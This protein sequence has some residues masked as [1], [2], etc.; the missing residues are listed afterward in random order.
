MAPSIIARSPISSVSPWTSPDFDQ[1]TWRLPVEAREGMKV[2]AR[3]RAK[4]RSV[5]GQLPDVLRHQGLA[6]RVDGIYLE[7][8]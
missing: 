2:V 7:Y 3:R 6:R 8:L 1:R 5:Q 4:R